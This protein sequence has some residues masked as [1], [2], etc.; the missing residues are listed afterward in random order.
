MKETNG[1]ARGRF[2]RL[3]VCEDGHA[4]RSPSMG[5]ETNE[6]SSPGGRQGGWRGSREE[7]F[8]A[9][10]KETRHPDASRVF[11]CP[12]RDQATIDVDMVSRVFLPDP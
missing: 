12:L 6:E 4:N 9:R 1:D 2:K 8:G 10:D 11:Y 5:R 7:S 3:S